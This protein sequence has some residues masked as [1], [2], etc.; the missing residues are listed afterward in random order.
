MAQNRAATGSLAPKVLILDNFLAPPLVAVLLDH[1]IASETHFRQA[2]VEGAKLD[3]QF[4]V[5]LDC[6]SLPGPL[7]KAFEAAI[8]DRLAEIWRGVGIPP[9][10][11]VRTELS[12]AAHRDR[13]YYRKHIDTFTHDARSAEPSDRIVSG[14]FYFH[15]QPK[16]FT[17]GEL[18]IHSIMGTEVVQT[19]EP[20]SNRLVVFPSFVPHEVMP[21]CLPGDQFAD[22]RFSINCWL[23]RGRG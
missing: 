19:I 9:F 4:R 11:V 10:P 21:V 14:V 2:K 12:L 8:F 18:A 6:G 16:A 17:G 5:A 22:A 13:A 23:H 15:R 7:G 1:A 3:P 20:R